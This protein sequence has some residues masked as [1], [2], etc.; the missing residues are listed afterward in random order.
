MQRGMVPNGRLE[1]VIEEVRRKLPPWNFGCLVHIFQR[2][3][4]RFDFLL[5]SL[6]IRISI[7]TGP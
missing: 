5:A 4:H 2:A 6:S 3:C 7:E 1:S